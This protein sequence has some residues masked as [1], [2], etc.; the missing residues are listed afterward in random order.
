MKLMKINVNT[1]TIGLIVGGMILS[2]SLQANGITYCPSFPAGAIARKREE[3]RRER[4]ETEQLNKLL[5]ERIKQRKVI[6]ITSN[7]DVKLLIKQRKMVYENKD[8]GIS[9]PE[10][11]AGILF[12]SFLAFFP[13]FTERFFRDESSEKQE[14]KM[15]KS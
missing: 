5:N 10:A 12:A 11:I 14:T 2:S 3:E 4:E 9:L 6:E 15:K 1:I 13:L 7:E 8:Q